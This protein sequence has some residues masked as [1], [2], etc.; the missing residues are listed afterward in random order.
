MLNLLVKSVEIKKNLK[1]ACNETVSRL[2]CS[3]P[4]SLRDSQI[5]NKIHLREVL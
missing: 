1:V 4:P 3:R 2:S 5:R